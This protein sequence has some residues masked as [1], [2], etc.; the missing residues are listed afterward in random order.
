MSD[1]RTG[2]TKSDDLDNM[3][4]LGY[5]PMNLFIGEYL[6]NIKFKIP[7]AVYPRASE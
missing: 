4:G 3:V 2:M 5:I 6:P 7:I 1:I